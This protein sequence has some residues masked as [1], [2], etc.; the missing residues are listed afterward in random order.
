M[1]SDSMIIAIFCSIVHLLLYGM[2]Y[3]SPPICPK[4]EA[5]GVLLVEG[6]APKGSLFH[7]LTPLRVETKLNSRSSMEST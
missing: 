1:F 7:S 6:A 2:L 5:W 4:Y 3:C